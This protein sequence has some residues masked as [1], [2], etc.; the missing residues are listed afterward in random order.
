MLLIC[1]ICSEQYHD[2]FLYQ[3]STGQMPVYELCTFAEKKSWAMAN[4]PSP[5]EKC[6]PTKTCDMLLGH[7]HRHNC[8]KL[9]GINFHEHRESSRSTQ[10]Q[11]MKPDQQTTLQ[12]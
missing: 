1:Y 7:R 12:F 4:V 8:T 3:C 2:Y 6:F 9:K 5:L 11:G 10:E